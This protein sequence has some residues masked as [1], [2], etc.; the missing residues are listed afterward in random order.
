M[1]TEQERAGEHR[2]CAERYGLDIVCI[3][4]HR[5]TLTSEDFKEYMR[6]KSLE[7]IRNNKST[8]R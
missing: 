4:G 1:W 2:E 8:K 3:A 6:R 7:R 5:F